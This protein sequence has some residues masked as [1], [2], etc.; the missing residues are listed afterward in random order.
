MCSYLTVERV[1]IREKNLASSL[2]KDEIQQFKITALSKFLKSDVVASSRF[3]D[4]I[5]DLAFSK[6]PTVQSRI[7]YLPT[8]CQQTEQS[9]S[10]Y[11]PS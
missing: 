11:S 7:F 3:I 6:F 2:E 10:S 9:L 1:S 4:F 5:T 8:S